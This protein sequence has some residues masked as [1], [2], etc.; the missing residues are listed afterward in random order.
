MRKIILNSIKFIYISISL[1]VIVVPILMVSLVKLPTLLSLVRT[2]PKVPKERVLM[3][4]LP[5][6]MPS[7]PLLE[8]WDP[9]IKITTLPILS[10][11]SPPL[12]NVTPL[13]V[14]C[15]MKWRSTW[16]MVTTVSSTTSKTMTK[17][18]K[19]SNLVLTKSSVWMSLSLLVKVKL[20]KPNSEPPS[21]REPS[22]DNTVWN[23]RL[24]DNSSLKLLKDS[25]LLLS[26]LE[27]SK[28]KP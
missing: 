17:R 26:L 12:I 22:K 8:S 5:L 19:N 27:L 2:V 13:K 4:S 3:L 9:E 11:R 6:S 20:R 7:K 10:K 24:L 16:S 1:L 25:P 23:W 28:M 14:F 15:L 21:S 18:L